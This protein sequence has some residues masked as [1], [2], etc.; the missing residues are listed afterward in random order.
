MPQKRHTLTRRRTIKSALAAAGV[1][2]FLSGNAAADT[3]TTTVSPEVA[4]AGG[5][6]EAI[7]SLATDPLEQVEVSSLSELSRTALRE[8]VHESQEPT[9]TALEEMTGVTVHRPFWIGNAVFAS[10]DTET[11]DVEQ[12]IASLPDVYAVYENAPVAPPEP[13]SVSLHQAQPDQDLEVTFGLGKVNALTVREVF[14]TA[15]EGASVAI[16]DTG[17]DPDHPAHETF[18]PDNF[19]EFTLMAKEVDTDPQDPDDHGT[20]VS[21]TAVGDVAVDPATDVETEIGVAPDAELL[22]AKV[23]STFD[24]STSATTAQVV[25]GIEWAVDNGADIINQ[26]LGSVVDDE[27]VYDDFYLQVMR[28][29]LEAG[30]L[31]VASSGNN[32][33]G[34]T[35]SPGNVR[36]AFSIA[37]TDEQENLADFSSGEQ[38]FV[39]EAWAN[40]APDDYPTFYTVPDVAAPGVDVLSSV[41][42]GT[43]A[44]FSGTSMSAPHVAGAA[45]LLFSA[46]DDPSVEEVIEALEQAAV[47][48][49]GP[50]AEDT[51]F[52]VGII[53]ALGALA[54]ATDDS[55][56]TGTVEIDGEVDVDGFEVTS[57]F[58]TRAIVGSDGSYELQLAAGEHEITFDEFGLTEVTESV[59]VDAGATETLDVEL[60]AELAVQLPVP[61][62]EAQRVEMARGESF[63]LPVEVANLETLTIE[64][65]PETDGVDE[66]DVLFTIEPL[67]V[68]FGVGESVEVDSLTGPVPLTVTV[69]PGG[70]LGQYAGD[71]QIIDAGGLGEAFADWQ[72]GEIDAALLNEAFSAWQSQEPVAAEATDGVL[73]LEHTFEGVGDEITVV[74]GPTDVIAGEPAAFEIVDFVLPEE[75]GGP[76]DADDDPN[77]VTVSATIENTGDVQDTQD[78]IYQTLGTDFPTPVTIPA[79]ETFE[80][81]N[82]VVNLVAAGF[83]GTTT[84]HQIITQAD[85]VSGTLSIPAPEEAED[86]EFL[87]VDLDAPETVAAGDEIEVTATI[88]NTRDEQF[89]SLVEYTFDARASEDDAVITPA[90]RAVEI[91]GESTET[92][93]FSVNTD[94]LLTGTY[95]HGVQTTTDSETAEIEVE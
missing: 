9:L 25:A 24:G 3:D 89:S 57:D 87:V 51:R 52:G 69:L 50:G 40:N 19:A 14:E 73:D 17:I 68:E 66:D 90:F 21:G 85:S 79:G 46:L 44:E 37:A 35:G 18:D 65:G 32:G 45:A 60:E 28:D 41:P 26:S 33:Q 54:A 58:G 31:P 38:V 55:A 16:V 91:D 2:A 53:D 63:T 22:N 30:V 6:T 74:T 84:E 86:G 7:I 34:L 83:G 15:G 49:D 13:A 5:Q 78:V 11:V 94:G 95:T 12:D 75:S 27:S 80:Y 20:H 48:P 62:E 70:E 72:A 47:H 8:A 10:I 82:T 81:E 42:G 64:F 59:T 93:T 29:T 88:E 76:E 43:Y 36:E 61:A 23:F 4:G 67:D 77:T 39:E 92:V 1:S 71:D 56:V